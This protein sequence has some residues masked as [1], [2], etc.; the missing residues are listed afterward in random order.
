MLFSL[1]LCIQDYERNIP[2]FL[3][4]IY[5]SFF[6]E[7]SILDKE[8]EIPLQALKDFRAQ[9]E[10]YFHGVQ[11]VLAENGQLRQQV[12]DPVACLHGTRQDGDARWRRL[13]RNHFQKVLQQVTTRVRTR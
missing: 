12:A 2:Y 8:V 11:Q 3:I 13:Q 6:M 4:N 5:I 7:V 10:N 9:R 1:Y